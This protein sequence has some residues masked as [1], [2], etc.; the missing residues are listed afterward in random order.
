[1]NLKPNW[2]ALDDQEEFITL[3]KIALTNPAPPASVRYLLVFIHR[4]VSKNYSH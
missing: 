1:M 3:Y 4:M 2:V